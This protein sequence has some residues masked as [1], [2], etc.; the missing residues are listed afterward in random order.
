MRRKD[1]EITDKKEIEAILKKAFVCHLGLSDGEQPYVVPMNYGYEDGHVY[2]HCASEGKRLDI[3][4]KNNK[5][6][7]EMDLFEIEVIK[8][9]EQPCDWGTSYRSVIGYGTAEL[10]ED[11][12]K[13][14]GALDVIVKSLDD[15]NFTLPME[16]V[17]K[18]AVID[19][20]VTEMTGKTSG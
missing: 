12:E 7:F 19:I 15:R 6:C 10:V 5:V 3:L 14:A 4:K 2:L 11:V 17:K 20:T 8:K 18:T 13:K 1:Q 16:V 9:N